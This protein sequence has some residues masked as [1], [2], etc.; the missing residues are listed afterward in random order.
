MTVL[1]IA[2][3]ILFISISGLVLA[4]SHGDHGDEHS[5]AKIGNGLIVI[6]STHNVVETADKLELILTQKGMTVFARIDHSA[7]AKKVEKVLR[8]TELIIFGNPKVGTPLMQCAQTIAIDLPQK[9]LIWEDSE[10]LT[11]LGY[12]APQY[13]KQRHQVN[14]CDNIFKKITGALRKFATAASQ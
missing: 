12:N 5:D 10:G 13:L 3:A 9:M 11:W 1:H 8:P 2:V 7:G 4:G 6:R 14:D